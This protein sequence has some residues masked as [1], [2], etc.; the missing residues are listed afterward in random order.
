MPDYSDTAYLWEAF[1][2]LGMA[3]AAPMGGFLPFGWSEVVAFAG[4]TGRVQEPWEFE[5]LVQ[6]SRQYSLERNSDDPFRIPPMERAM[7]V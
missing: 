4:A 3:Q 1:K 6:M 7:N 2:V 5:A